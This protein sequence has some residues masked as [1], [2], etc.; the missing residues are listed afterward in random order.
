MHA[1]IKYFFAYNIP[2]DWV[3]ETR[4]Y[5]LQLWRS[6]DLMNARFQELSFKIKEKPVGLWFKEI[7]LNHF[8]FSFKSSACERLHELH[9][10]TFVTI[11]YCKNLSFVNRVHLNFSQWIIISAND[12]LLIKI[13]RLSSMYRYSFFTFWIWKLYIGDFPSIH[14]EILNVISMCGCMHIYMILIII[15]TIWY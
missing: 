10:F 14:G 15:A 12:F 4:R 9:L 6:E 5:L 8:H 13:W 2:F 11:C 7:K 1:I 3:C